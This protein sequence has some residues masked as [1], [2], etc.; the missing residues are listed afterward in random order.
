MKIKAIWER[1]VAHERYGGAF[2]LLDDG[3]LLVVTQER[4]FDGTDRHGK[5]IYRETGA[6]EWSSAFNEDDRFD[7]EQADYFMRHFG[8]RVVYREVG[9][10]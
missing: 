1:S 5:R 6:P 7:F 4:E 2:C 3:R 10:I 9:E 8:G